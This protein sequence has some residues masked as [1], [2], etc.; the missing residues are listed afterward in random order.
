[1]AR[2]KRLYVLNVLYCCS[3]EAPADQGG[4]DQGRVNRGDVMRY[5][6]VLLS[7]ISVV[8]VSAPA[9]AQTTIGSEFLIN[10]STTGM[11]RDADVAANIYGDFVVVWTSP[12]AGNDDVVARLY[13]GSGTPVSGEIT[14]AATAENEGKPA[15]AVFPDGSF[16]VAYVLDPAAGYD[17]VWMRRF[18]ADGSPLGGAF[19]FDGFSSTTMRDPAVGAAADGEFVVAVA[20]G[21]HVQVRRFDAA[22][23]SLG[24][25]IQVNVDVVNAKLYPD[26]AVLPDKGF[27][28]AW[29]SYDQD[30][31]HY[32]VNC[33]RFDWSG[34]GGSEIQV[35]DYTIAAQNNAAIGVQSDGAYVIAWNSDGQDGSFAGV[36]ARMFSATDVKLGTEFQVNTYVTQN[37]YWPRIAVNGQDRF[38]ITWYSALQDGSSNGVYAQDFDASG[39]FVGSEYQVNTTTAGTQ[40]SPRIAVGGQRQII[41]WEGDGGDPDSFG[42]QGQ[43]FTAPPSA[44]DL[45]VTGI[46]CPAEFGGG[47]AAFP[48]TVTVHNEGVDAG[49][50]DVTVHISDDSEITDVDTV[51]DSFP[52]GGLVAGADFTGI[53]GVEIPPETPAGQFWIGAIADAGNDVTEADENNNTA[54]TPVMYVMPDLSVSALSCPAEIRDGS[55]AFPCTVTVHNGGPDTGSFGVRLHLSTD[56]EITGADAVLDS[57][58][59]ASLAEQADTTVVLADVLLPGMPNGR[60]W[61]GAVADA[62]ND[63]VE[64]DEDN[65]TAAASFV[66]QVPVIAS[67][68]D[69]HGDQG[70]Q[71]HL[72]WWASPP[73]TVPDGTITEYTV[74][75]A[76]DVDQGATMLAAGALSLEEYIALDT[77]PK[78]APPVVR[79][80]LLGKRTIFWELVGTQP[81]YF[82]PGYSM[83]VP[84]L[85]DSTA[86]NTDYHYVQVIA[87]LAEPWPYYV[88]AVDSARSTDDLAPGAL[89]NLAADYGAA[90][91]DLA[92]DD[93]PEAD[94][95][96]YRV[97][98]GSDPDFVVGPGSLVVETAD[99]QWTDA[100]SD[101][102][103]HHYKVSAVDHAG[104]EG[105]AV[106]PDNVSDVPGS[107]RPHRNALHDPVPNPF[108]PAT[109]LSFDLTAAGRTRLVIY[110]VAGRRVTILVDGHRAAGRHEVT[111]D[112]RDARGRELAS[113]V[114]FYRLDA[115]S[116]GETKR[117]VLMR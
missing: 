48:C 100:A 1:M 29:T 73:D 105:P 49:S 68:Q 45:Y 25:A 50:F 102:W 16:V 3:N 60:L 58:T 14:V 51:L 117:M 31:D 26:V 93:A 107:F 115:G 11:Q 69:V 8:L 65:N 90:G 12:A 19:L 62:G 47:A 53:L 97:Y 94:F 4:R 91:V 85:F 70:G 39:T 23:S 78:K 114:Y 75:R 104:N 22:G 56:D 84:T 116:F 113:G 40:T 21:S 30:G 79:H 18:A 20:A 101:P 6:V 5:H 33:R 64:S 63:I 46:S 82:L 99:S 61:I 103:E 98:R 92:W 57:F 87:H 32:G 72:A 13:D 108:N 110:D 67:L 44:P 54:S 37:Q 112:G 55:A 17:A 76:I 77:A 9:V 41:V 35:N 28:V 7:V 15:V 111:W 83:A 86:L 66:N 88:S 80:D 38:T 106:A 109:V 59:V 27:I 2:L 96:V 43:W 89:K 36:F 24:G 81:A 95:Q 71:L 34:A 52:V 10:T 74:W 42:I